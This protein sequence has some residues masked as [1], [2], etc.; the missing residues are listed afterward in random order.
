MI[1]IIEN[2]GKLTHK[3][4]YSNISITEKSVL[5]YDDKNLLANIP[6]DYTITI[7][8]EEQTKI[9]S[10]TKEDTINAIKEMYD[11]S[12]IKTE[13]TKTTMAKS[14]DIISKGDIVNML[15]DNK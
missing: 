1:A 14:E 4:D 2:K 11:K 15:K 8:E 7:I 5:F 3:I 9:E 13:G 6:F 12:K 10:H